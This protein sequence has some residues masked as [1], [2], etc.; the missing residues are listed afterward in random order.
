MLVDIRSVAPARLDAMEKL[1]LQASE[2]ALALQNTRKRQGPDLTLNF[3]KIGNRPSGELSLL[4][5][6]FNKRWPLHVFW[7]NSAFNPGST[8]ANIPISKGIPAVTVG[9]GG[10]GGKAHSLDEWWYNDK[11]HE[12]IQ[13]ALLLVL[14]Q[15]GF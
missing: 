9:R 8:D 15:T 4:Y 6:S 3:E 11:G 10:S 1:L 7:K 5:R 14:T 13:F 12:A 2:E